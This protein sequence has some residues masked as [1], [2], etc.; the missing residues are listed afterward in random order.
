MKDVAVDPVLLPAAEAATVKE[1]DDLRAPGISIAKPGAHGWKAETSTVRLGAHE[2]RAAIS[3]AKPGEPDARPRAAEMAK[4][5]AGALK[6][7]EETATLRVP[8]VVKGVRVTE[9]GI[10]DAQR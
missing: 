6:V 2:W 7:R 10:N 1:A 4:E 8:N 5:C 3:T 9:R